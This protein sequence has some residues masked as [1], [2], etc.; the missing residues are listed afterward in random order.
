MKI[1]VLSRSKEEFARP[2]RT[3]AI[4]VFRNPNPALHPFERAREYTRAL[5][6][7]KLDR[8][9]ARPFFGALSGHSDGVYCLARHPTSL[10]IIFSGSGDGEIRIWSLSK[11]S[12]ISSIVGAHS[13]IIRGITLP[14]YGDLFLSC[15]QDA[16]VKTWTFSEFQQQQTRTLLSSSSSSSS[17]QMTPVQ[18]FLG[19]NAFT[20]IDHQKGRQSSLFATSGAE[21][22]LWDTHRS[23]PIHIF[24]WGVD[25]VTSVRFNPVE[26]HILG[27]TT[28]DRAV[29][30]YD[31]RERNPIRKLYLNMRSNSLSWNPIEPFNFSLANEDHNCYT[32]DMRKMDKALLVHKDH[33]SAVLDLDYSPT[34][35]E[36]VTGSYDRSIRIFPI[37]SGRSREVYHTRR[38]QRIFAVKFSGDAKFVLSASDDTN[39]RLWKAQAS[40]PLGKFPRR[41]KE[42]LEYY[43]ALKERYKTMPE[44]RRIARHRHLPR[45][46][47]N[48]SRLLETM[49]KAQ[50]RKQENVRKHSRPGSVPISHEK[51]RHIVQNME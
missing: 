13:S 10:S 24:N 33:V 35:R 42:K 26:T 44:I 29:G 34:G 22:D 45:A 2:R 32:F 41:A 46:I 20:G 37:D 17:F 51:T 47:Y 9:F 7:T 4:R 25:T 30:L 27:T 8:V 3:D 1:K 14:S 18:T 38:M 21:L 16:T 12:I 50:Q 40:K 43:D 39:I 15:G 48:T 49:K 36:F 28:S 5:N 11:Q 6:A 19:K 23:S 31:V